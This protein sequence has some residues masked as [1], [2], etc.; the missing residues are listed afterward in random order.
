MS[1]ISLPGPGV[2]LTNHCGISATATADATA[3]S[4][5]AIASDEASANA[6][7]TKAEADLA[8]AYSELLQDLEAIVSSLNITAL[9]GTST[10]N[11]TDASSR[12]DGTV[13]AASGPAVVDGTHSVAGT[14][15]ANGTSA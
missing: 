7:L 3:S 12:I 13:D 14:D 5:T 4:A 8:A 9:N 2:A 1:P 11:A 15:N 10:T 6:T